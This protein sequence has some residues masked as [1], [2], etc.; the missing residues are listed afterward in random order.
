MQPSR[1]HCLSASLAALVLLSLAPRTHA[2]NLTITSTPPGATVE[3]DGNVVG[4]TPY[5]IEYPGAYFH[6]PHTVFG[7]RLE[8]SMT[9]RVSKDGYLTQ[10]ITLT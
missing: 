1:R 2:E 4:P 5:Q 6:K 10:E 9:L 3:I 7:A 8:R